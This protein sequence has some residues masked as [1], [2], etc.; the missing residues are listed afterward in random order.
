M[1]GSSALRASSGPDTST[2]VAQMIEG[3]LACDR[4]CGDV[5]QVRQPFSDDR[6]MPGRAHRSAPLN[7]NPYA[8]IKAE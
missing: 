1:F 4:G 8:S 5:A 7:S 2:G 6:R 3:M